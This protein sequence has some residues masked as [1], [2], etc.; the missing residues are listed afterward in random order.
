MIESAA[1]RP[2]TAG[3]AWDE[4]GSAASGGGRFVAVAAAWG[5]AAA[6]V[7]AVAA[8][9]RIGPVVYVIGA[10]H[11]IHEG[12]VLVTVALFGLA[13][14]VTV[15][16]VRRSRRPVVAPGRVVPRPVLPPRAVVALRAYVEHAHPYVEHVHPYVQHARRYVSHAP[17]NV[18]RPL[19]PAA[20]TWPHH[21]GS[22]RPLRP[23]APTVVLARPVGITTSA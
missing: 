13:L 7:L 17:P 3:P 6:I 22:R 1:W 18:R 16:A 12:D 4:P 11:G 23:A 21:A 9:T 10:G 14:I 8:T 5:F 19:H 2:T 15:G 20:P